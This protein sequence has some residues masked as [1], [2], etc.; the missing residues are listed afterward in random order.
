M[1]MVCHQYG[2]ASLTLALTARWH[3]RQVTE[4]PAEQRSAAGHNEVSSRWRRQLPLA[5]P[6]LASAGGGGGQLKFLGFLF[7]EMRSAAGLKGVDCSG[8]GDWPA[9]SGSA[10]GAAAAAVSRLQHSAQLQHTS[11]QQSHIRAGPTPQ[12]VLQLAPRPAG[13]LLSPQWPTR[14]CQSR[15]WQGLCDAQGC[16]AE[17]MA[18]YS[19]TVM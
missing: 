13:Q 3:Q 7:A 4:G 9:S 19:H 1:F 17:R 8:T 11:A 10:G 14:F 15:R 2:G 12:A 6:P 5:V 16:L 18:S